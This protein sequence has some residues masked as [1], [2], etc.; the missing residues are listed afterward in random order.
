MSTTNGNVLYGRGLLDA[1]AS[2]I[3]PNF[4]RIFVVLNSSDYADEQYQTLAEVMKT[5][6]D[7]VVRYFTDLAT[8][9]AATQS[10]NND[11]ICLAAHTSHKVT[12]MLTVS[13]S[14]VHFLGMDSGGRFSNQ[15]AIVSNS[16]AG[17]STDVSM[18]KVTGTG[19][20]F[21][22]IAFKNNWTVAQNLSAVLEYGN[23]SL[24]KNCSIQN[25]GSAHLTNVNA[26][27]LILAAGDAEFHECNI[28]ADTLQTTVASGQVLLIKKGSSGQA[29]TRCLFNNC[30]FRVYTSQSTTAFVRVA[31]DG[32]IDRDVTFRNCELLNFK[33]S[34]GGTTMAVA[35]A[36]ASGLT[37]GSM[38]FANCH[39][40]NC[41]DFATAAVGNAATLVIGGTSPTAGSD[42]IAVQPTA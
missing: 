20:T 14:R 37:S 3:G 10:N 18:I 15:R 25:L 17:A 40:F 42:G 21:R 11:V 5:D 4:G 39:A 38:Y 35:V 19:C 31:A 36:S 41:T 26:A 32:D 27:P 29:A 33:T 28:G 1:V 7:G 8:A 2:A 24:Y 23:N 30:I 6:T 13:K 12:S 34:S 16:G 22:N 9:Y